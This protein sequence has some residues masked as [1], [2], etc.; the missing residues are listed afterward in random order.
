MPYP[1]NSADSV[2]GD[3]L[4]AFVE[5][6]ERMHEERKAIADDIKEIYAEAKANGF[7]IP[8]LKHVIKLRSKDQAE[9]AEFE[10]LVELYQSALGSLV[11]AHARDEE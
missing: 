7:D 3:Q 4:R 10:A 5:R 1:A 6:V 2:A 8:A 11:H 9:L